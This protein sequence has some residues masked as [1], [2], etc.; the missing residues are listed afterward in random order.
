LWGALLTVLVF[1]SLLLWGA[2]LVLIGP[3]LGHASWHA[4]RGSVRWLV[5]DDIAPAT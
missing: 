2:G 1:I 4:Y 3:W 5:P